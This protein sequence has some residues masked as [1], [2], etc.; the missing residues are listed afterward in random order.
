[1]IA[2]LK[3]DPKQFGKKRGKLSAFRSVPLRF[4]RTAAWRAVFLVDDDEMIVYVIA[5]GPHDAAYAQAERRTP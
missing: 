4:N 1:V 3:D 2:K 5:F